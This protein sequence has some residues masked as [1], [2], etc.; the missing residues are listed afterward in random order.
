MTAPRPLRFCI[1]GAA[2]L[3]VNLGVYSAL[4]GYAGVWPHAAAAAAF[5]VAA[6][7]NYLANRAWTFRTRRGAFVAQGLR[8][9][10][11]SVIALAVNLAVLSVLLEA[12]IGAVLAQCL[13][14]LVAASVGFLGNS[15]WSFPRL[16]A[17]RDLVEAH[18]VSV[19]RGRR[20]S[21]SRMSTSGACSG[22]QTSLHE[23]SVEVARRAALTPTA[24]PPRR[25]SM[26]PQLGRILCEM[27]AAR[28]EDILVALD[29]QA[30]TGGRLG[31]ILVARGAIDSRDL[32]G[33]LARQLG[34][35]TV[36]PRDRPVALLAPDE[37][38]R[39]RSPSAGGSGARSRSSWPMTRR[40]MRCSESSTEAATSPR[41]PASC[42]SGAPSYRRTGP[43][44]PAHRRASRRRSLS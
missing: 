25:P 8:F 11:V 23:A 44:S 20:A 34:M 12:G 17:G 29:E 41:R 19:E 28:E 6:A 37:A 36:G 5:V 24:S 10:A 15:F 35:A 40:S 31:Q 2:G 43:G 42:G 26:R 38:R 33:A 14:V 21:E 22:V 4:V 30:R 27:G 3:V 32:T 9:L 39:W 1:V 7:H 13:S 18:A 16:E